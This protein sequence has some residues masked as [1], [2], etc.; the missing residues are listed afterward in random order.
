METLESRTEALAAAHGAL[1]TLTGLARVLWPARRRADSRRWLGRIIGALM[2]ATGGT[3]LLA[4]A[5]RK[6]TGE[7]VFLGAA[8][9]IALAASHAAFASVRPLRRV[10]LVDTGLDALLAMSWI[11]TAMVREVERR[12]AEERRRTLGV[13]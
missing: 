9:S 1:W 11:A 7:I 8:S 10:F 12:R 5:R 4:G 3:L 13:R 6:V 2:T